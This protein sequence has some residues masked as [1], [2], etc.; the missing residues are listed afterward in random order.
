MERSPASDAPAAGATSRWRSLLWRLALV[1]LA[2]TGLQLFCLWSFWWPATR[3]AALESSVQKST[4]HLETLGESL[5]P[6]LLQHQLAA[7]HEILNV[8]IGSQPSWH[9]LVLLNAEG[10]RLYPIAPPEGPGGRSLYLVESEIAFHGQPYGVLLLGLD[11]EV[12]TRKQIQQLRNLVLMMSGINLLVVL[13]LGVFIETVVLRPIRGLQQAAGSLALGDYDAALPKIRGD[14]VGS[15]IRSFLAMR[16]ELDKQQRSLREST[17]RALEA[18]RAKSR[19]L[20]SMS[21]EIRTPLNG[22]IALSHLMGEQPLSADQQENLGIIQKSADHLLMVINN[23]LDFSKI[24]AGRV[25]MVAEPFAP[26]A[27]AMEIR[28]MVQPLADAK[29][30]AL[31]AALEVSP[32]LYVV[33]DVSRLRQVLLNL[34]NNA[35]KF[36]RYGEVRIE[37][38]CLQR[39]RRRCQ[40]ELAVRDTGIGIPLEAQGRLFNRFVQAD[41]SHARAFGGT[42]LGL[43]ISRQLVELMGGEIGLESAPGEGSRFWMV[44]PFPVGERPRA[45]ERPEAPAAA[46]RLRILV[47]DDHL[48]NQLIARKVLENSGHRV[49]VVGDGQAAVERLLVE[50]FDLVL[51]DMQMPIMDGLEATRAIR[52][53]PLGDADIPIVALTANAYHEAIQECLEAGMDAY[54]S[55]PIQPSELRRLVDELFSG[56]RKLARAV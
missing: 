53:S 56:A 11:L 20:S 12:E 49:A 46:P 9:S 6:Y 31:R 10:R 45:A 3:D 8:V 1:L 43:A 7:V 18:S 34:T 26:A 47:A 25:E 42:G 28:A 39:D 17:E 29:G 51:M 16:D 22:I 48:S 5:L 50:R 4:A 2:T 33:G 52:A 35:V 15:L 14:E 38:R 41:A 21:H 23:I 27:L 54:L 37:L 32:E 24:E 13:V 55:K 44:I 19:F 36:T 40:L 30:L